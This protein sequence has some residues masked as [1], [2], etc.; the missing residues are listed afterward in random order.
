MTSNK[1]NVRWYLKIWCVCTPLTTHCLGYTAHRLPLTTHHSLSPLTTHHSPLTT[2]HCQVLWLYLSMLTN[3][4]EWCRL[5]VPKS[6]RDSGMESR[7]DAC[8]EF[9]VNALASRCETVLDACTKWWMSSRW[10]VATKMW[11]PSLISMLSS[12]SSSS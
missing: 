2:H 7:K 11:L 10:I 6:C 4:L 8:L 9:L 1:F 5:K 12:S 3:L